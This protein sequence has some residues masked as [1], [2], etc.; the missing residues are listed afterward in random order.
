MKKYTL[1]ASLTLF[2]FFLKTPAY[3]SDFTFSGKSTYEFKENGPT[4]VSQE[5]TITNKTKY[6]YPPTY[7]THLEMKN[8]EEMVVTDTSGKSIPFTTSDTK[9]GGKIIKAVFE[10]RNVGVGEKTTLVIKYKTHDLTTQLGNSKEINIPGVKNIQEFTSYDAQVITPKSWGNASITKPEGIKKTSK[11]Y[12]LDKNTLKENGALLIFGDSEYYKVALNYD[13]SNKNFFPLRTEIALPPQ[14]PYQEVIYQSIDPKPQ[15]IVTDKDGNYMAQ[16][17][18]EPQEKIT[19]NAIILV[20]TLAKPLKQETLSE[21]DKKQ[22]TSPKKFWDTNSWEV[23]K[24]AENLN[25]PDEIYNFLTKNFTYNH[26]K[27]LQGDTRLGAARAIKERANVVCLEFTDLFVTLARVSGIPARS[28]EGYAY[29]GESEKKPLSFAGDVLHAWPE[30]YSED[31]KQ[32]KMLDPTWGN[33]TGLDYLT[34]LD[35]SH[36]TFVK[37]GHDTEY[38]IPPGAYKTKNDKKQINVSFIPKEEFVKNEKLALSVKSTTATFPTLKPQAEITIL[39]TG[40]APQTGKIIVINDTG[41]NKAKIYLPEIPPQGEVSVN[42]P[43]TGNILTPT[44]HQIT[45]QI[46]DMKLEKELTVGVPKNTLLFW[47]GGV[48]FGVIILACSFKA[49][50]LLIQRR[51]R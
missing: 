30:Y 17:Q 15:K 45:M 36:I 48:A 2:F 50:S 22:Y 4:N 20:K 23:R 42:V 35:L 19:V 44:T 10:E 25:S 28:V 1:L 33:T 41:S 6:I 11:Y 9:S 26:E 46:D 24:S 39:N 18:L 5:I 8:V 14:T 37:K 38:P 40:N 12:S 49:G 3:A 47:G 16:Y 43:L 31:E 32:W 51:R 21:K 29:T 27:A 7:T 13:L 34:N